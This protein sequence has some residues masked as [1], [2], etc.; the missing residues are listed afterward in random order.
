M[1]VHRTILQLEEARDGLALLQQLVEPTPTGGLALH[2]VALDIG[3]EADHSTYDTLY[4]AFTIAMDAR[5]LVVADGPFTHAM[6]RHPDPAVVA[7]MLPLASW[8]RSVGVT[9]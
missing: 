7:L 5:G 2:D 1:Q 6:Q 3:L 4:L 8:A 9:L